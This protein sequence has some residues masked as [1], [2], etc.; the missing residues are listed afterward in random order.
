MPYQIFYFSNPY[1]L[2][3]YGKKLYDKRETIKQRDWNR[4]KQR[5]MGK[6]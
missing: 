4:D 6:Y 3:R 2:R 1:S 5:I